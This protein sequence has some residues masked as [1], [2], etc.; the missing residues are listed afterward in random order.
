M[1][2][3][4]ISDCRVVSG[5]AV[6]R[7]FGPF[8]GFFSEFKAQG[9]SNKLKVTNPT[10]TWNEKESGNEAHHDHGFLLLALE[11]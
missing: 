4:K 9:G 11:S 8:C 6:M 10:Y 2:A 5:A 1:R 3:T 7:Q